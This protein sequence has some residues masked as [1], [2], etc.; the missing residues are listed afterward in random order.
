MTRSEEVA[1]EIAFWDLALGQNRPDLEQRA[2]PM[3][4]GEAC[5]A[6]VVELVRPMLQDHRVPLVLDV[7]C[8]PLSQIAYVQAIGAHLIGLDELAQPYKAL[9]ELHGIR[10]NCLMLPVSIDEELGEPALF[11]GRADLV[12]M[13]NALDHVYAPGIAFANL[14]TLLSPR[15]VLVIGGF[16][17][18]GKRQ[19][20]QGM[21]QIDIWVEPDNTLWYQRHG[22]PPVAFDTSGFDVELRSAVQVNWFQAIIRRHVE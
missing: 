4:W 8:G 10:P 21:H 2:K 14:V 7:G 9:L 22:S 6:E 3:R 20:Y 12:W 5:P 17:N 16:L 11:M 19:N 18:E 13:R 15:G 1:Q